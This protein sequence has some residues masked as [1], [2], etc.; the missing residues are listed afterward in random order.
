[1]TPS[2]AKP[3]GIRRVE[4]WVVG[5]AMAVVALVLER[6]VM[7]SVRAKGRDEEPRP[8]TVTSKGSEVDI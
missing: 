3:K 1:M 8:T 2:T 5:I 6:L 4:R 7:R